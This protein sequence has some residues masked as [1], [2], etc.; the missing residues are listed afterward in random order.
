MQRRPLLGRG[1]HMLQAV[2][3]AVAVA[4]A[5]AFA[6]A[7]AHRVIGALYSNFH[8]D[9]NNMTVKAPKTFWQ[10]LNLE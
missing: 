1:S 5:F 3:V 2:R 4:V 9:E 6:F 8:A 7:E 10:I